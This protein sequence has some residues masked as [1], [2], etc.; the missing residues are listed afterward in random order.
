M[1]EL[2]LQRCSSERLGEYVEVFRGSSIWEKYFSEGNRL[3]RS[4]SIA[5]E[6]GE[7]W[8]AIDSGDSIV[9]VMRIVPRGFCGLYH[10][11]SL[12]GTAQSMRGRG[13]GRFLMGEFE[14]MAREDGCLRTSLMVSD[15][16][17]GAMV[18]YR[19]LGYWELGVVPDAVKPGIAEHLMLKDLV[20]L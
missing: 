19:S 4:L 14:R 3:Q 20:K 17:A 2:S 13:V 8:C 1:S 5:L 15:F 9:G 18:F 16:N 7:L 12:I 11:L 10:Y 6:R